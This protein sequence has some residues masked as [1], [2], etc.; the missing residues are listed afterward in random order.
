M[1]CSSPRPGS[2][3]R[4]GFT[5]IELL[6]VIAIIG[7]LIALLLP[8]VQKI[9]EAA[10]RIQCQNNLKQLGLALHN[11]HDAN[12]RFPPGHLKINNVDQ[13]G[14]ITYILPYIEQDNLYRQYRFDLTWKDPL[15]NAVAATPLKTVTCP[16]APGG[17]NTVD[18][19]Q[20][21]YSAINIISNSADNYSDY[22]NQAGRY[23]NSGV[24]P[25]INLT[26]AGGNIGGSHITD[27]VDGTSNTILMA[28]CAGREQHW[29]NGHI[30]TT[31]TAGNWSGPWANPNNELQVRGFNLATSTQ[32]WP[33]NSAT[34]PC[35]VNC[36]NARE[37]YAFHTGGANSV[38]AD[39]SVHFLKSTTDL[40]VLRS[41]ITINGGEI[42]NP[43]F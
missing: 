21:D 36:T 29:L 30:D 35:A 16:A 41:L 33:L 3:P 40:R 4:L 20:T 28:E 11:Y 31:F 42:I 9:R 25:T 17:R 10:A 12:T 1:S 23:N 34:P 14:C 19:A 7:I 43:D 18:R 13:H 15:N 6:V 37:V 27:I 26:A 22:G 8:A 39:G 38:F 5:L 24:L 2:R 32:G